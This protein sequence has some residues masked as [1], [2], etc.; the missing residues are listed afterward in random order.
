MEIPL[1]SNRQLGFIDDVDRVIEEQLVDEGS[2]HMPDDEEELEE[3]MLQIEA[4]QENLNVIIQRLKGGRGARKCFLRTYPEWKKI[5][6]DGIGKLRELAVAINKDRFNCNVSKLV[7][8]STSAAG[9][10]IIIS[11]KLPT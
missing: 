4:M 6:G 9:G 11:I 7:G 8:Y 2:Y 10:N 1:L 5:R 3:L